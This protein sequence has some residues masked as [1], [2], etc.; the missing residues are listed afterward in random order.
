MLDD[1]MFMAFAT[2]QEE[3][4]SR[5]YECAEA[6]RNGCP[7]EAALSAY[8]VDYNDWAAARTFVF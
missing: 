6:I 2:E 3:Y 1:I 7:V 8:D 4:Q 5:V